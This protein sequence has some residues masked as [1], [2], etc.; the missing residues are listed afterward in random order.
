MVLEE[1]EGVESLHAS[2]QEDIVS[3][4]SGG[5]RFAGRVAR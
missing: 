1:V 4:G 5:Y 2:G 3:V